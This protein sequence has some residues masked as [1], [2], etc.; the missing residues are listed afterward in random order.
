MK[1]SN[2]TI[3]LIATPLGEGGI[4]VVQV[5]GPQALEMAGKLFRSKRAASA[6]CGLTTGIDLT[7]AQGG[8]LFYGTI[9]D[10]VGL[11]DEV[12]VSI[13]R[14]NGGPTGESLVEINCHGGIMAVRKTL[15]AFLKIGAREGKW[16]E[17]LDR[18]A[19]GQEGLDLIQ[20][21][22][23]LLLPRAKT[24]L[25]VKMLLSQY[26]SAPGGL[27]HEVRK[28]GEEV[29][30]LK[31]QIVGCDTSETAVGARRAVPLLEAL[32]NSS[33]LGLA[34]MNPLKVT[35]AGAPNV[36]K[37]TLFNAL[38]REDRVLVHHEPGTTRDYIIEFISVEGM[39][40]ELID[41]AGLREAD[42]AER[43]GVEWA[44]ALHQEADKV[45]LVLDASRPITQEEEEFIGT[46]D[47]TKVIPVL[48][49]IDIVGTGLQPCPRWT[50]LKV[51]PYM[52]PPCNVSALSVKGLDGLRR[53]LV[54]EFLPEIERGPHRPIVFTQ[55]QKGLLE[56]ALSMARELPEDIKDCFTAS[57]VLERLDALGRV[58]CNLL[59]GKT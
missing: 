34:L 47:T 13:W 39:P 6:S 7:T 48:N 54:K 10:S 31:R 40:L 19:P 41:T 27:S 20:R 45:I 55:R 38:L 11:I 17:L 32:V 8:S 30:R 26:Q 53:M 43:A 4:G 33:P 1:R 59:R 18:V 22:A 37:S 29:Q 57:E 16:E 50:D 15:E 58:L 44:R 9:H 14:A 12:L 28:L 35:I 42:G 21:E 3:A 56:E 23:L 51:C 24:R 25:S 5:S 46:L 52:P 49:K 2:D 36:G